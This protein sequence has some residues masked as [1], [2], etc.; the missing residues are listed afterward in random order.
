MKTTKET[1]ELERG[2]SGLEHLLCLQGVRFPEPISGSSQLHVIQFQEIWSSLLASVDM[3]M[4][5]AYT[6]KDIDTYM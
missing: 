4:H 5:A 3:H 1:V 2:L 6:L